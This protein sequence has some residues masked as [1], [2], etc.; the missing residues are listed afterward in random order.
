MEASAD[1]IV[2]ATLCH[3]RERAGEDLLE[4][5]VL[6]PMETGHDPLHR[7]RVRELLLARDAAVHGIELPAE[8]VEA[9]LQHRLVHGAFF[10]EG[11]AAFR[12]GLVERLRLP[13][14]I[15]LVR[16]VGIRHRE[17]DASEARPSVGILRWKIGAPVEHL[18][19]RR[20]EGGEGPAALA[21][22]RADGLLVPR[23]DV[24]SLVSVHLDCDEVTVDDGG[25]V[26]ILVRF[27][28]DHVAPVAPGG[29]DVQ[30]DRP[31]EF[32]RLA[33]CLLAP[34]VPVDGLMGRALQVRRRLA[35]QLVLPL[36]H[37]AE[38][39]TLTAKAFLGLAD[40]TR[41]VDRAIELRVA[42]VLAHERLELREHGEHVRRDVPDGDRTTTGSD[43]L[44][45]LDGGPSTFWAGMA[46]LHGAAKSGSTGKSR[47]RLSDRRTRLFQSVRELL[48]ELCD[49]RRD[50]DAAIARGR[51][52]A[53]VVL[54]VL[55]RSV[56]RLQRREFRDDRPS[57]DSR[58]EDFRHD[59][60]RGLLLLGSVVEGRRPILRPDVASLPV[61]LGRILDREEDPQDVR[62]RNDVR[63]ERD[64]HGLRVPCRVRADGLVRGIRESTAGVSDLHLLD[65]A[66][67]L[68]HRLKAPE[69]PAREG[70]DL[71]ALLR[72]GHHAP[73]L[74]IHLGSGLRFA[75]MGTP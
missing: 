40:L 64:L 73:H 36:R 31:V 42:A 72:L 13:D 28:V 62:E 1:L 26:R 5:L 57:P 44:E 65:A 16:A 59:L 58:F 18:A 20:Q 6:R 54:M 11:D 48:A 30:E 23:V 7:P 12:Q 37:P 17:Q 27:A 52:L 71:A 34:R 56:E 55:L 14:R 35:G 45:A 3:R 21:C 47:G 75:I 4:A 38:A 68:E 24:R 8:R 29:P 39:W 74:G 66:E 9:L 15:R 53:E 25:E 10:D 50:D 19:V 49:L 22:D 46:K 63:I 69:T 61:Q 33:E 70:D 51:V 41:S 67:L 2:D 60:P 32:L 43:A